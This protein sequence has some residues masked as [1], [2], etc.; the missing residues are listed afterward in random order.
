MVLISLIL[1]VLSLHWTESLAPSPI[2]VHRRLRLSNGRP[3]CNSHPSLLLYASAQQQQ[4][5]DQMAVA[6]QEKTNTSLR[7]RFRLWTG[8]SWTALRATLRATTGLSLSA[9]YASAV[10][11]SGQW[12]RQT[13]KAILAIF[14]AWARYFVQPIL[15]LYYAP[16]F[17]LRNLV[18]PTR[19]RALSQRQNLIA[20]WQRAVDAANEKEVWP[21]ES[22]SV[23]YFRM[24]NDN[25]DMDKVS[26]ALADSVERQYDDSNNGDNQR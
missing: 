7:D 12:L 25:D 13:M 21:V 3:L 8:F 18:G 16:I 20:G 22:S 10:A 19:Q 26:Q 9:L 1:F 6:E 15:I 24:R 2:T 4:Q 14:P 11:V 17:M 23:D 5:N